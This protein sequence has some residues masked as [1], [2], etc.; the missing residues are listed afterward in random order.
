MQ[1]IPAIDLLG[2][3]VVRLRQ[4]KVSQARTYSQNCSEIAK[5]LSKQGAEWLHVVDLDAAFATGSNLKTIAEI[6]VASEASL[7]VGGGIRSLQKAKELLETGV[8]RLILGTVAADFKQLEKFTTRFGKKIWVSCDISGK[9]VAV[10]GWN[11]K[12]TLTPTE[13]FKQAENLGAGGAVVTDISRDGC[14]KGISQAF[15]AQARSLTRLPLMAAGGINRIEDLLELS[16]LGYQGAIVGTAFYEKT[17]S[18]SEA[19]EALKN[20]R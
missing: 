6:A 2:G 4:G 9:Q 1:I 11:K 3:K 8:K 17:I 12:T 18:V 5:E 20:A 15:F 13:L 10:K 7:Q 16:T 14:G 19:L